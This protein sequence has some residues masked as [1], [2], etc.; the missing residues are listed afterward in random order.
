MSCGDPGSPPGLP[1]TL[2][3]LLNLTL[4]LL[5]FRLPGEHQH[6]VETVFGEKPSFLN[7]PRGTNI[8]CNL[9]IIVYFLHHH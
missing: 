9:L 7:S 1:Y 8:V 4:E 2:Q 6:F 5:G 3:N